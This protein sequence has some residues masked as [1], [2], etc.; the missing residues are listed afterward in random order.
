MHPSPFIIIVTIFCALSVLISLRRKP[1]FVF[2]DAFIASLRQSP[3]A[4]SGPSNPFTPGMPPGLAFIGGVF[5]LIYSKTQGQEDRTCETVS[6]ARTDQTGA[7]TITF[8]DDEIVTFTLNGQGWQTRSLPTIWRET[9]VSLL[10]TARSL[11]VPA[12]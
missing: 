1:Y 2:D 9:A 6:V 10:E 8:V 3:L 7:V 4:F 11:E 12:A 5:S